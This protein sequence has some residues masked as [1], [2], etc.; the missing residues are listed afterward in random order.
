MARIRIRV[1]LGSGA[2]GVSLDELGGVAM[3]ARA[4]LRSLSTDVGL[5]EPEKWIATA[6]RR[7]SFAFDIEYVDD[8]TK[9]A[10]ISVN[11][12]MKKLGRYVPSRQQAPKDVSRETVVRYAKL[13]D[14]L[15]TDSVVELGVYEK[16][17]VSQPTAWSRLSRTR[18]GEIL[19]AMEEAVAFY[20]SLQGTMHSVNV[21]A[22]PAFFQLRER[23][24]GKLVRCTFKRE[25]HARVIDGLRR[26]G[27]VVLVSGHANASREYREITSFEAERIDTV[28]E[29]TEEQFDSFVGSMPGLTGDLSTEEFIDRIRRDDS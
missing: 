17:A 11:S 10:A 4:F 13:A 14:K 5:A 20:G 3:D 8:A 6:P 15:G 26:P 21:G 1:K 2:S 19:D 22:S 25:L 12:R 24:G 18:A 9:R 16:D 23:A 28:D 27:L 7:G 29:I